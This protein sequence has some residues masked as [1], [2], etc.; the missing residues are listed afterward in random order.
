MMSKHVLHPKICV[1][2]SLKDIAK[3]TSKNT[4][5]FYTIISKVGDPLIDP[6]HYILK[7]SQFHGMYGPFLPYHEPK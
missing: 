2:L 5:P 6:M 7:F 1:F 4:E 3:F